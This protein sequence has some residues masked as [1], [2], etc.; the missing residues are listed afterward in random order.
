MKTLWTF[1][2]S[3]CITFNSFSQFH[4]QAEEHLELPNN[5]KAELQKRKRQQANNRNVKAGKC[6]VDTLKYCHYKSSSTQFIN[7]V[8]PT[9]TSGFGQ[10][11]PVKDSV[12]I[13]GVN[14]YAYSFTDEPATVN[15]YFANN[16]LPSGLPVVSEPDTIDFDGF[17]LAR[18]RRTVLFSTPYVATFDVVVTFESPTTNGIT[19]ATNNY[20]LDDGAGAG[21][22]C[23]KFAAGWTLGENINVTNSG[24][25][26]DFDA[27]VYIEPIV[28]YNLKSN[29]QSG[30]ESCL[31]VGIPFKFLNT[32]SPMMHES[33]NPLIIDQMN[34]QS[35]EWDYGDGTALDTI[36]H[37]LH[38]YTTPGVQSYQ[39]TLKST[40]TGWTMPNACSDTYTGLIKKP[41]LDAK[42]GSSVNLG[43]VSFNNNS[44][45]ATR[46]V[47][48]FGDG[49]KL[50]S[51]ES[52]SHT[53][54]FSGQY[55]VKLYAY[56]FGCV[57]SATSVIQISTGVE[58]LTELGIK[59]FPNPVRDFLTVQLTDLSQTNKPAMLLAEI[60]TLTG[61][62]VKTAT[63]SSQEKWKVDF[64]GLSS[65]N[66][67]LRLSDNKGVLI[68][69]TMVVKE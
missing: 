5:F 57:D 20:I 3:F 67:L 37:G 39:V 55:K 49:S 66:Y 10:Y 27:D 9:S 7:L 15:V 35:F 34:D 65:G 2:L 31:N 28:Q 41:K 8:T 63:I 43:A 38:T 11:F 50:D 4:L 47:W 16:K 29:F 56:N 58:E 6:D 40:H 33:Y 48:D 68:G 62:K 61:S 25:T 19:V 23:A 30:D 26:Y 44:V 36:E 13:L 17:S 52:P 42:F 45:D 59:L 51:T 18:M 14:V 12:T 69:K 54:A 1:C 60:Y 46:W 32:S 22:S 53:Y 21:F 24:V 64:R